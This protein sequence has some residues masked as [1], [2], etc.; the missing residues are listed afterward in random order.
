MW[1]SYAC[2]VVIHRLLSPRALS[3]FM[4]IVNSGLSDPTCLFDSHVF[5]FVL[6]PHV[7]NK[8]LVISPCK[9]CNKMSEENKNKE[10]RSLVESLFKNESKDCDLSINHFH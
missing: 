2:T 5:G 1:P 10:I 9:V 6:F 3:D 7:E 8:P 4:F